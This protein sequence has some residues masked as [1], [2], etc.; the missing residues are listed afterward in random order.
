MVRKGIFITFEGIDGSGKS[1]ISSKFCSYLEKKKIPFVFTCEPS[2]S[3]LGKLTRQI[4]SSVDVPPE[5]EFLL[6]LADRVD[7]FKN[8]ILPRLADGKVVVSDRFFDSSVAYQG[9][10]RGIGIEKTIFVHHLF[11]QN[12]A[13]DI[14]FYLDLSPEVAVRRKANQKG[15]NTDRFEREEMKFHEK[16][17]NAYLSL[18]RICRDRFVVI[19]ADRKPDKILEDVIST[20]ES[21]FGEML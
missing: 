6:F 15:K 10:G 9:G 2:N 12:F 11:L 7:H 17:R 4:L 20:F 21:R 8:F 19:D 1:T 14:T 16:V 13:P 18:S 3:D 5:S